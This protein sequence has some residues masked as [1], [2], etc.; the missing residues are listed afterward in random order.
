VN[1]PTTE[2]CLQLP[3]G[4]SLQ[5]NCTSPAKSCRPARKRLPNGHSGEDD[6]LALDPPLDTRPRLEAPGEDLLRQRVLDPTLDRTLERAR[7][8]HR[9]VTDRHQ[10]VQGVLGQ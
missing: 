10:L 7:A 9:V 8:V 2:P 4:E 3:A 6:V 1:P 5:T